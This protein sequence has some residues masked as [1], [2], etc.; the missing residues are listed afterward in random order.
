MDLE[1]QGKGVVITGGSRGIGRAITVTFAAEG[2]NVALCA[3]GQEGI[4]QTVAAVRAQGVQGFGQPADVTNRQEVESFLQ[5]SAAALGRL[6]ILM[7][8]VGPR[9]AQRAALPLNCSKQG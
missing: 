3:R 2:A 6:D 4:E 5:A 9:D 7:N 1:L 8:N